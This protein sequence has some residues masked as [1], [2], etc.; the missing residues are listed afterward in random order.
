MTWIHGRLTYRRVYNTGSSNVSEFASG[1]LPPAVYTGS[2][3]SSERLGY[4][5]DASFASIGGAKAGIVYDFYRADVTSIY[6]VA[7]RVPREPR[8]P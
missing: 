2:R 1:L 7:R 3:I 4:A 5:I 6:A 8:S